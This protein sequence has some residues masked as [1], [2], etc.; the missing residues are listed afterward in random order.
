[1]L[2]RIAPGSGEAGPGAA[3]LAG[4]GK[5]CSAAGQRSRTPRS[6][7][8]R[9]IRSCAAG[10]V[11]QNHVGMNGSTPSRGVPPSRGPCS[12]TPSFLPA[13]L[14]PF[15]RPLSHST[16]LGAG[17]A[18]FPAVPAALHPLVPA[19]FCALSKWQEVI[20]H[21]HRAIP[22]L[23][24]ASMGSLLTNP[25]SHREGKSREAAARRSLHVREEPGG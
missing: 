4:L 12:H 25:R 23:D 18:V 3:Q 14:T 7:E 11:L 15:P 16:P 8:T 13:L 2:H 6:P 5:S 10:H 20:L 19:P 21:S 9:A 22:A 24:G 17:H 1:M